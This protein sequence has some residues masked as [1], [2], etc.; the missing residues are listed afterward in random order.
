MIHRK[1]KDEANERCSELLLIRKVPLTKIPSNYFIPTR[2]VNI[3]RLVLSG[4]V[5]NVGIQGTSY[6]I[7]RKANTYRVRR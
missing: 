7:N 4:V 5:E 1:E 6:T 2:P 3:K